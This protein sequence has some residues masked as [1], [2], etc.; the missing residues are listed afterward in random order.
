MQQTQ[1]REGMV[2]KGS[3]PWQSSLLYV[4]HVESPIQPVW[5]LDILENV[6]L[7]WCYKDLLVQKKQALKL[8]SI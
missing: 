2:L 4:Q 8:N 3:Q 6:S 7:I 1:S 5:T